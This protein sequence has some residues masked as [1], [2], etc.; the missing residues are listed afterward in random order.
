MFEHFING[1]FAFTNPAYQFNEPKFKSKVLLAIKNKDLY[2]ISKNKSSSTILI[3]DIELPKTIL[4]E[5]RLL[6]SDTTY[7]IW[8]VEGIQ[9][10]D[11][12]KYFLIDGKHRV[13]LSR[14]DSIQAIIFSVKEIRRVLR[15]VGK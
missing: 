6:S 7:P 10:L 13:H 3:K 2:P 15:I 12:K 9:N 5:H 14:N 1:K 8:V 11:N 4:W